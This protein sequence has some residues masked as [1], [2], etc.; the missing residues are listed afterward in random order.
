MGSARGFQKK[1]AGMGGEKKVLCLVILAWLV[2]GLSGLY[3]QE[4]EWTSIGKDNRNIK[5][6][7]INLVD[8]QVI[9]FGNN[10]GVFKSE[11]G[12]ENWRNILA[13]QKINHLFLDKNQD[14]SLY[15]ASENGLWFSQDSGLTWK[16]VFKGKSYLE[17]QCKAVYTSANI[18]YLGTAG[19]LFQSQDSAITWKKQEG[20][21]SKQYIVNIKGNNLQEVFVLCPKG[22]YKLKDNEKGWERIF[23]VQANEDE[24]AQT[25]LDEDLAKETYQTELNALFIDPEKPQHMYLAA[26]HGIWKS[27]DTGKTWE[28]VL[29]EGLLSRRCLFVLH[30]NAGESLIA[31]ADHGVFELINQ[32]WQLVPGNG[33]RGKVFYLAYDSKGKLYAAGENGLFRADV[34]D[35]NPGNVNEKN[36]YSGMPSIQSVQKAAVEYAEVDIEKIRQWRTLAKKKAWLPELGM[37]MNRDV[38]DLWHWEGGSTTKES[39]DILRKGQDTVEW[40]LNLSWDLADLVWSDAQNSI[41]VRSRLLVQLRDDILDEVNKLYFEYIRTRYELDNITLLD[42]K[43]VFEKE[44]RLKEITAGLDGMTNGYFSRNLK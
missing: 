8:S 20:V 43:K 22:I 12:G 13:G 29:E 42:Q 44:V 10:R 31:A 23:T 2:L 21:L 14:N 41:D 25:E 40:D 18:I 7:A 26:N 5:T 16:K 30:A 37:G 39:D 17:S 38:T 36:S 9:Y 33:I 28:R 35:K 6:V 11:D 27:L 3:A 19:G 24:N 34:K 15:A 32:Q 4:L 1:E